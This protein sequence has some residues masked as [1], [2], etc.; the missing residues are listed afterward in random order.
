MRGR[1]LFPPFTA[2]ACRRLSGDDDIATTFVST[3][4]ALRYVAGNARQLA[5]RR[6]PSPGQITRPFDHQFP[7]SLLI[8]LKYII[9]QALRHIIYVYYYTVI[10]CSSFSFEVRAYLHE[11]RVMAL[12]ARHGRSS[13]LSLL[14]L[15]LTTPKPW[16][17][18]HVRHFCFPI[19]NAINNIRNCSKKRC[20]CVRQQK[21]H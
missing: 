2:L 20:G 6:R 8:F 9:I 1:G 21:W 17:T 19:Y 5:R 4:Q 12:P 14:F 11:R 18:N 3:E 10:V 16:P 13:V 15:S 7:H